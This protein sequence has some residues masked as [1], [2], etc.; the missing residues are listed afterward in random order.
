MTVTSLITRYTVMIISGVYRHVV[1]AFKIQL[2]CKANT[3]SQNQF[4]VLVTVMRNFIT[5]SG[6]RSK[7]SMARIWLWVGFRFVYFMYLHLVYEDGRKHS[8]TNDV[9]PFH[10]SM[11]LKKIKIN[12]IIIILHKVA[13]QNCRCSTLYAINEK[14]KVNW[15]V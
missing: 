4:L 8:F 13:Q 14:S 11:A 7:T 1:P 5:Y 10:R 15:V 9:K 12:L 6:K 2:H 3:H